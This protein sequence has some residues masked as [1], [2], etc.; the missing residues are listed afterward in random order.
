ML[1]SFILKGFLFQALTSNASSCFSGIR[2]ELLLLS[3]LL[4][5]VAAGKFNEFKFASF[6]SSGSSD[7]AA[8]WLAA[9]MAST[10]TSCI[11][12]ILEKQRKEI[13][14]KTK[15]NPGKK[16]IFKGKRKSLKFLT[17]RNIKRRKKID[18]TQNNQRKKIG[19]K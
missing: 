6:C 15:K 11:T 12:D 16:R 2:M 7:P 9:T 19:K 8:I 4:L 18:E 14:K 13:S 3:L 17:P 1:F 5:L 10:I